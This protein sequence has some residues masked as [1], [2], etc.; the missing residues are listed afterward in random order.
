VGLAPLAS[1]SVLLAAAQLPLIAGSPA[2]AMAQV[3]H[4]SV[5]SKCQRFAL[6]P[7]YNSYE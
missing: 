2:S 6:G 4:P 5:L 1:L 7:P 3:M